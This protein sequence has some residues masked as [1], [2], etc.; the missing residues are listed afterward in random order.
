MD[1]VIAP[2]RTEPETPKPTPVIATSAPKM[3]PLPPLP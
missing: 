2:V 1:K 3:E